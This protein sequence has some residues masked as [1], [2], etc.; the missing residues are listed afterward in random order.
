[1]FARQTAFCTGGPSN[2][3]GFELK[4]VTLWPNFQWEGVKKFNFG[5]P[6]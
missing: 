5:S 6:P 1:M 3:F 2:L 4:S